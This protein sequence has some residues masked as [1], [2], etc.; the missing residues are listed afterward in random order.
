MVS[1]RPLEA[2]RARDACAAPPP[3][4]SCRLARAAPLAASPREVKCRLPSSPPRPTAAPA[5]SSAPSEAAPSVASHRDVFFLV[6]PRPEH[7]ARPAE[8]IGAPS[9]SRDARAAVAVALSSGSVSPSSIATCARPL[10]CEAGRASG[11]SSSVTAGEY[12][13]TRRAPRF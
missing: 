11:A 10:V 4:P 3:R 8:R 5:R 12:A 13:D 6:D 7:D 2:A 9:A 1:P